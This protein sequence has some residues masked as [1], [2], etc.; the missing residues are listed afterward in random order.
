MEQWLKL[1]GIADPTPNL[2]GW[3]PAT[4]NFNRL[5]QRNNRNLDGKV[6][7]EAGQEEQL[8]VATLNFDQL[9]AWYDWLPWRERRLGAQGYATDLI[10][11]EFAE[12]A[13]KVDR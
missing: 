10:A 3:D 4:D 13:G 7:A 12:I 9:A 1:A 5:D 11:K 2:D 6:L 8:I